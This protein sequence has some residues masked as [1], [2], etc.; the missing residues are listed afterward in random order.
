[1]SDFEGYTK[2][3][4]N[5]EQIIGTNKTRATKQKKYE[6]STQNCAGTYRIPMPWLRNFIDLYVGGTAGK[7]TSV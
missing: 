1:M 7:S 2:N 3:K 4:F 5:N 6:K